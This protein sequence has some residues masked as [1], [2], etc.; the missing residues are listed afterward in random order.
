[1]MHLIR[2][3]RNYAKGVLFWNIAL[4]QNSAP[5]LASVDSSAVNRGFLTIRS[6]SMDQVNYEMAYYSMGHSSKFVDPG[7][8]R[9]DSSNSPDDVETVA[10]LN[11]DNSIAVVLSNRRNDKKAVKIVWNE[12]EAV[13]DMEGSSATT[14]KWKI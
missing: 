4:D 3:P 5:K 9:I 8:V 13:F 10:Y 2:S 11:P 7:A 6:D 1:M 14:L 12:R